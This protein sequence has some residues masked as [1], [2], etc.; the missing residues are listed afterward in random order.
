MNYS[1]F[2]KTETSTRPLVNYLSVKGSVKLGVKF[3]VTF[4]CTDNRVPVLVPD[5]YPGTK[6]PES[7]STSLAVSCSIQMWNHIWCEFDEVFESPLRTL[8]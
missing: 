6:I 4:H 3:S 8:S 2:Q 7:P 5:G 1:L